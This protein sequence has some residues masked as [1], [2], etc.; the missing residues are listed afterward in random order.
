MLPQLLRDRSEW[1]AQDE[2]AKGQHQS[3]RVYLLFIGRDWPNGRINI[4]IANVDSCYESIQLNEVL[5]VMV[6][7]KVGHKLTVEELH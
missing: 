5:S 3:P 6:S 7:W 2:T 1:L 4:V